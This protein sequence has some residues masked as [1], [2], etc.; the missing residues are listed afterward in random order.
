[1]KKRFAFLLLLVT[2]AAVFFPCCGNDNCLNEVPTSQST[3]HDNHKT[4]GACSPFLSCGNCAG[5]TQFA[6]AGFTPFIQKQKP[7][8]FARVISP[9]L[10]TYSVSLLQ[11]PRIS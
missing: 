4:E 6:N 3:N 8:H 5:F 7:A 10:T 2:L 11:P 1:M 9:T